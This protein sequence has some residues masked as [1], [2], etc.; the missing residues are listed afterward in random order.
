MSLSAARHWVFD[1]DGTLTLAVHDFEAI[2]RA[3]DIP[4]ADDILGHLAGLPEAVAA[5]KH[6][7]LLEHERELA[8]ASQPAPGAIELVREL[9]E[10]G[11]RLGILTRNAHELALLTLRAIGL[12]DCF[13]VP[14]VIGRD[15]APPKPDPGGLLHFARTWQVAP[16]ELV[17]VGDYRFDLECARAAGARSVLVNLPENPWPELADHFAVDCRALNGLL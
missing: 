15:E 2:K 16:S 3:L 17:M 10:R 4:L 11:C 8:L 13:A 5:A 14:D 6:A 7:W 1:M 9:R 12:D